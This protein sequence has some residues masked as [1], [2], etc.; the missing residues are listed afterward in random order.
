[1]VYSEY[2]S[3]GQ[4]LENELKAQRT[5]VAAVL[6]F[7]N[8]NE[9][10]GIVVVDENQTGTEPKMTQE[11]KEAFERN[12]IFGITEH[13]ENDAIEI[14]P[15]RSQKLTLHGE[16]EVKALIEALKNYLHG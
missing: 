14:F 6:K 9:I 10:A 7:R 4:M 16:K 1:M 2:T 13:P 5:E 12:V 3:T 11:E 8:D 15:M